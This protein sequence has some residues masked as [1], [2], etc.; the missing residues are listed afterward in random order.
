MTLQYSI[1]LSHLFH[2]LR[3]GSLLSFQ[4]SYVY[5]SNKDFGFYAHDVANYVRTYRRANYFRGYKISRI[6]K[7]SL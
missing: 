6:L 3:R 5:H 7:I 1:L 2:R 4:R